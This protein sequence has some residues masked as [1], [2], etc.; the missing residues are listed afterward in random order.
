MSVYARMR[1]ISSWIS[2]AVKVQY[3]V[4]QFGRRLRPA[5]DSR[6]DTAAD[7]QEGTKGHAAYAELPSTIADLHI[8]LWSFVTWKLLL[9]AW[10][11]DRRKVAQLGEV[12]IDISMHRDLCF[13]RAVQTC[14]SRR[15][16]STSPPRRR[17]N[18]QEA[19]RYRS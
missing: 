19:R 14:I 12:D 4:S 3:T 18:M 15:H 16:A 13:I 1:S 11:E 5:Q 2:P 7:V 6:H 10:D 9:H 8:L 17:S